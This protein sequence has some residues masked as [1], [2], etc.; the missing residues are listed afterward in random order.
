VKNPWATS[1]LLAVLL[2]AFPSSAR[3]QASSQGGSANLGGTS[4][5]LV[6]FKGGDDRT[7]IPEDKTKYTLTF[8]L[9]AG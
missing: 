2:L 3:P 1:L 9:M 8:T 5:Q 6:Q 4:W 7:L